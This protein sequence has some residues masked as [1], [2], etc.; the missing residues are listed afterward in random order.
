MY[1]KVKV[2][3][4]ITLKIDFKKYMGYNDEQ[5]KIQV[6]DNGN[7]Y[8]P[9]IRSILDYFGEDHPLSKRILDIQAKNIKYADYFV[10]VYPVW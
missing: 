8:W 6:L 1:H 2:H 3:D 7:L 10:P 4:E 5:F 9:G